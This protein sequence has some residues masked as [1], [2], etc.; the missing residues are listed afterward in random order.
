MSAADRLRVFDAHIGD[1]TPADDDTD[2]GSHQGSDLAAGQ[3]ADA[4]A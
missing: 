4:R 2:V 1:W 3:H